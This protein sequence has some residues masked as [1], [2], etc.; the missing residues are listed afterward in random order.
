MK[1]APARSSRHAA[2]VMVALF[3]A[4]SMAA[5]P[6]L[7]LPNP[8]T[9][10]I[11]VLDTATDLVGEPLDAGVNPLGG[12]ADSLTNSLWVADTGADSLRRIDLATGARTQVSVGSQPTDVAVS[13]DGTLAFVTNSSD[14]TLSVVDTT[15]LS[16]VGTVPV[17]RNPLDVA[18]AGSR[19]YVANF[20]DHSISVVDGPTSS[21]VATVDVP[22][23]PAGVSTS[24]DGSRLFVTTFF[25]GFLYTIDT[26]TN[27]IVDAVIVGT[28]PRGVATNSDGSRLYVANFGS[29]SISEIDGAMGGVLRTLNLAPTLNPTDVEVSSDDTRLYVTNLTGDAIT[30]I[31][32]ATGNT[33]EIPLG[34]CH[35]AIAGSSASGP[36]I[37]PAEIPTLGHVAA[38]M[39]VGLIGLAGFSRLR[40]AGSRT[41]VAFLLMISLLGLAASNARAQPV[42][43]SDTE[44]DPENW[45]LHRVVTTAPDT[46]STVQDGIDGNPPPSRQV[47]HTHVGAAGGLEQNTIETW[48]R[49]VAPQGVY[50]PS[51]TGAIISIDISW[52]RGFESEIGEL[53]NLF[54]S[55]A[56]YQDG[57]A[58]SV[59]L[60][61]VNGV[62][63]QPFSRTGIVAAE[64]SPLGIDFSA[65][66]GDMTFGFVRSSLPEQELDFFHQLDNFR[67]TINR[68]P[69][70]ADNGVLRFTRSTHVVA[71]SEGVTVTVERINGS[72]G[73]VSARVENTG[74]GSSSAADFTSALPVVL[75]WADGEAGAQSF[76]VFA[77][78]DAITESQE[79]LHLR[80]DSPTGGA[81]ID[82]DDDRSIVFVIDVEQ[83]F[84]PLIILILV[85]LS[86]FDW[87]WL[88]LVS[89]VLLALTA[90][91]RH[92]TTQKPAPKRAPPR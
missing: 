69:G 25:D 1:R 78:A 35:V 89:T 82:P 9:G 48:H 50:S 42:M 83:E 79:S 92:S 6:Y 55:F 5:Q 21:V 46:A 28:E 13:A 66:G 15:T 45:I 44:F 14:D 34:C 23:F 33:A 60:G 12:A 62:I 61:N 10:E 11:T 85:F 49:F 26:A 24:P 53:S 72:D 2:F 31:D 19:A 71:E 7:Y 70:G 8:V 65:S 59:A 36:V 56:I 68:E 51:S 52:D 40:S 75:N 17:G 54:E 27:G 87:R 77:A 32:L 86:Q 30:T 22:G 74:S 3:F 38:L 58:Y 20:A 64:F 76:E 67:V 41:T 88:L 73:P 81:A 80:L 91:A 18:T 37:A 43:I 57:Q 39:L 90:R 63:W 84:N 16:V 29:A 47:R 4:A